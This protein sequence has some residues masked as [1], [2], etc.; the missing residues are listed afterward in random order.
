MDSLLQD[1][2]FGL[3]M[4]YAKPGFTAIA[5]L[6]VA[7]GIG[8]NTAIF[9]AVNAL[10]IRPLPVEDADRLVYGFALRE[11]FDPFGT[12]LLE[13][14]AYREQSHSL[15]GSGVGQQVFLNLIGRGE[16]ERLR[17][18][19]VIADY[20]NTLGIR[21]FMGRSFAIEE[22]QPGGPA[23]A[24][25]GYDLWQRRFGGD[26]TLIGQSLNLGG[27]NYTVVGVMPPGFNLPAATE[28]WVPLQVNIQA[29]PLEQRSRNSF[30]M[31]ARLKPG[32]SLEQADTELKG[33]AQRLEQEY[34]Q[35]RR[36]WSY[37]I[38]PL[39]QQLLGDLEGRTQKALFILLVAVGFLLLICC[40]N[41]ANLLLVRGVAREHEI[42]IR[43][44]LGAGRRRV[45]RQLL[46]ESLLLALIGGLAGLLLAF[47]VTPLLAALN[48]I[49]A[50]S[51][52][53]FLNDFRIDARVL[54]FS[55]LVSLLTGAIFGLLP[56]LKNAGSGELMTTLKQREQRTGGMAAG[57]RWLSI[58]IVAEVAVA[59]TLLVGGGLMVQSFQ[60]L[61]KIELGFRPDNLLMMQMALSANKYHEHHQRVAFTEQVLERVKALPGITSAGMT[62]NIPLQIGSI[63]SVFTV[64]GRPTANPA[65][66]PI[67]AFRVVSP[68][69]LETLGVELIKGRLLN[70][71]DRADS[72]PVV[73][74]SE[75]LARQAWPGE[76]PI[77][78]RIKRGRLQQTDRPWMTVVGLVKD[79]KEDRFNFRINR[80]VWYLPYAQVDN[81]FPL[82]LVVRAGVDPASLTAAVRSAINT[83]D[84]DQPISNEITMKT[85]LSGVLNT[86]HFSAVLMGTLAALGLLLAA[87]GLYGVMAYSVSQ[88]T[89]EIGL[90]M[91]LGARQSDIM[92]LV[93]GQGIRLI[94]IGL[95]LGLLA[96]LALTR[97]LSSTLYKVSPNDPTTFTLVALLL[98]AVALLACYI[99]ARRAIK[100]EPVIALRRD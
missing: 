21:P 53:S 29:L 18:A 86:E 49:Q 97:L 8:A 96:A 34:P 80:P 85:Y 60:N 27:R 50:V 43:L 7:L 61:Q 92:K 42:A 35:I 33:I 31:I 66:V 56:A 78:K 28:I 100:V 17:G 1:L 68:D 32:V 39:R 46:T 47:W 36:G 11:G 4:L 98:S 88:R 16:P 89:G 48:P 10:L 45:V 71:Q 79:I 19:E 69:Y 83:I 15:A 41:V 87:L 20:L 54:K 93:I 57:R 73:V 26:Q 84:P 3:R 23:V 44:A 62:T 94:F 72:L 74:V 77:G 13:Y 6:M 25:I 30:E 9:S 64:E 40:A 38:I 63:D 82:N 95:S 76:D 22:D 52:G 37:K 67:T 58:L 5:V 99:P 81:S 14:A 65:D 24:L 91:A 12:S 75:E 59:V 51:L 2:R 90:R 55:L 70:E